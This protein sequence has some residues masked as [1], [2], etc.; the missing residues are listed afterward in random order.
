VLNPKPL[1]HAVANDV[2]HRLDLG[3]VAVR[4]WHSSPMT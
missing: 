1:R 2:L 4:F 3:M